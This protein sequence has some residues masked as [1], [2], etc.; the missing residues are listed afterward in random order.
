[1]AN[2]G[3]IFES[4]NAILIS[5]EYQRHSTGFMYVAKTWTFNCKTPNRF[6]F[7]DSRDL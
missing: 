7:F 3:Q 4:I 1:M 6:S 2:I 5:F